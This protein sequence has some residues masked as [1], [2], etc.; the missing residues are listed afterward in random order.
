MTYQ[1]RRLLF[2][3]S[4]LVFLA[5]SGPLLLYTFGYRFSLSNFSLHKTGGVFA[6]TNPTGAHLKIGDIE[7]TTSYLSGNV[8]IQNLKPT[9][10][11][12]SVL[13]EGYQP[14]EKTI[15]VEPQ[16]V[17]ELFPILM[18]LTPTITVLKT[19]S[20]TNMYASPKA[21]LLVLQHKKNDTQVY[22][23]F[24][25]NL[26]RSLPFADTLSKS[27]MASIPPDARW[28]W[29]NSETDAIIE[30]PNDWISF[31]R[32]DNAIHVQSLYR[33]TPL[34]HILPKKPLLIAK[35]PRDPNQYF[36]LDGTNFTHWNPKTQLAQQLLQSISGL[37]VESSHL[38]LWD[39]QSGLPQITALDTTQAHPYATTSFPVIGPLYM[40]EIGANLLITNKEGIWLLENTGKAPLLLTNVSFTN[41]IIHTDSYVVWW[42]KKTISIYWMASEEQLPSFQKK[43]QETIYVSATTIQQVLPYPLEQY[44]LVKEDN[45]LYAMELDGRGGTR[46]KHILYKGDDP[47]FY[48]PPQDKTLYVYDNG[49]L[50]TIDLP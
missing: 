7:R 8:F 35:D 18:P 30:T 4:I 10:Y 48:A 27:L 50:F 14:W 9:A 6:H 33:T 2:F 22:E 23:I 41:K 34:K 15:I 37:L 46:N 28:Q 3:T 36:L 13:S 40:Q 24:D 29:N 1:T 17:T 25:P 38:L 31:S 26:R 49:S 20:S 43:R 21:S 11:V 12:I 47:A 32:R 44:L 16:M 5:I 19:A 39:Q 42:D 45:T